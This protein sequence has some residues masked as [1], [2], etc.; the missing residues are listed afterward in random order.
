MLDWEPEHDGERLRTVFPKVEPDLQLAHLRNLRT[1]RYKT[2][3][4][5]ARFRKLELS[6]FGAGWWW[7]MGLAVCNN[8]AAPGMVSLLL[9]TYDTVLPLG[10]VW[11]LGTK[12]CGFALEC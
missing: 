3:L 5:S 10:A 7:F 6:F 4:L 1:L 2:A 8:S 11:L 12:F 9:S